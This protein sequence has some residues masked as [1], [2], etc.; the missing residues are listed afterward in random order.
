MRNGMIWLGG[1]QW[2]GKT[3][4]ANLLIRFF[5]LLLYDYDVRD[6]R[7]HARRALADPL[8]FPAACAA[9]TGDPDA[10]W[11]DTDPPAMAAR[12]KR[13]FGERFAMLA[14][15]VA[16]WPTGV[17]ILAEGWGLRP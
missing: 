2:A 4:L 13:I 3:T 1:A 16:S 12:A 5:P 6:A 15:E 7:G 8:R 17:T 11:V 14:D 9:V 10:Q